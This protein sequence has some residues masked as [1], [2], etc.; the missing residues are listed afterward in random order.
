MRNDKISIT[1]FLSVRLLY[2]VINSVDV[3]KILKFIIQITKR[4]ISIHAT[5]HNDTYSS[6]RNGNLGNET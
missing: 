4:R 1:D 2:S 3:F 5:V 6:H